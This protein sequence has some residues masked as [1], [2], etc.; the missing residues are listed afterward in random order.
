[1]TDEQFNA[2]VRLIGAMAYHETG[3]AIHQRRAGD[4][5]DDIAEARCF[6]VED[7]EVDPFS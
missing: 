6:L 7:E 3:K 5:D 2:L 1:M 4:V